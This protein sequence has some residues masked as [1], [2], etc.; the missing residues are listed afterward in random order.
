MPKK[1]T[2][3]T[4]HPQKKNSPKPPENAVY[5]LG[6][7]RSL[8]I[9]PRG[10]FVHFRRANLRGACNQEDRYASS[11]PDELIRKVEWV[12]RSREY[13]F[14]NRNGERYN[15]REVYMMIT[16][17]SAR[18]LGYKINPHLLRHSFAQHT[19]EAAPSQINAIMKHLGHRSAD[20]FPL[21]SAP[22][23]IANR[24]RLEARPGYLTPIF[25]G[26]TLPYSTGGGGVSGRPSNR[27]AGL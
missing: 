25:T 14:E 22:A 16:G 26:Q 10:V 20:T 23:K 6:T 18:I 7:S 9:C 5:Y 3:K 24:E 17:A 11:M 19:L 12:C 13:L 27:A 8:H 15:R 21:G 4:S 2:K 1:R